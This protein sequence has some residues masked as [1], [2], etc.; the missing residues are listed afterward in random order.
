MC[1]QGAEVQ[2][3]KAIESIPVVKQIQGELT[4]LAKALQPYTQAAS[5]KMN[6]EALVKQLPAPMQAVEKELEKMVKGVAEIIHI[7]SRDG[8]NDLFNGY[9]FN[10]QA[11]AVRAREIERG[12]EVCVGGD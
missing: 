8:D 9:P 12:W 6:V 1:I 4:V 10:A 3:V 11:L 5:A 2:A 7:I